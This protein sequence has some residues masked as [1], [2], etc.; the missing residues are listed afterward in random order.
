MIAVAADRQGVEGMHHMPHRNEGANEKPSVDLD[1]SCYD[2]AVR[3]ERRPISST[4][5]S[6]LPKPH[7]SEGGAGESR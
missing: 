2:G 4:L 6:P 7:P 5:P 3:A 1:V